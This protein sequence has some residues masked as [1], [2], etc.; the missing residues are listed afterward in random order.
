MAKNTRTKNAAARNRECVFRRRLFRQR[1]RDLYLSLYCPGGEASCKMQLARSRKFADVMDVALSRARS[2]CFTRVCS[3]GGLPISR[4]IYIL[5]S[6][7]RNAIRWSKLGPA[8]ISSRPF[9]TKFGEL[10][11]PAFFFSSDSPP[12]LRHAFCILL[13]SCVYI[14]C[15]FYSS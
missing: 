10:M 12:S 9:S 11:A 3:V 14:S 5:A 8:T 7:T 2:P 4:L 13:R 6:K 1:A 15:L